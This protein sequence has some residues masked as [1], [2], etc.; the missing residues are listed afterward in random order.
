M[1]NLA[2][3]SECGVILVSNRM[4]VSP[5]G[6]LSSAPTRDSMPI[7]QDLKHLSLRLRRFKPS[8]GRWWCCCG[9]LCS[10]FW[11]SRSCASSSGN[12]PGLIDR[13]LRLAGLPGRSTSAVACF[14]SASTLRCL[15]DL[16]GAFAASR[17]SHRFVCFVLHF[18]ACS[19]VL[20]NLTILL[21]HWIQKPFKN[22]SENVV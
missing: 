18:V 11:T 20:L 5:V 12:T 7:S 16:F 21:M 3:C 17:Q 4:L 22:D 19:F 14:A 10:S 9:A 8:G 1:P 13:S 6:S 2:F 15:F